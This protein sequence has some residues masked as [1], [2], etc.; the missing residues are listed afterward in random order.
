[1]WG[2]LTAGNGFSWKDFT[3]SAGKS[4][5]PL[6]KQTGYNRPGKYRKAAK[7]NKS[8]LDYPKND[9]HSKF[10]WVGDVSAHTKYWGTFT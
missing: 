2:G 9:V 3:A 6:K 1:M 7:R 8:Q 10:K 5:S 4:L